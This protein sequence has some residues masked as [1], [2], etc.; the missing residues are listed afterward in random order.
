[1]VSPCPLGKASLARAQIRTQICSYA[2]PVMPPPQPLW[3]TCEDL[4]IVVPTY[5]EELRVARACGE[6]RILHG[7]RSTIRLILVM[8]KGEGTAM[9]GSAKGSP[10]N[11]GSRQVVMIVGPDGVGRL[12]SA[13]L[14]PSESRSMSPS[15]CWPSGPAPRDQGSCRTVSRAGPVPSPTATLPILRRYRWARRSTIRSTSHSGG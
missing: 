12:H 9:P 7:A 14:S 1:M 5:D 10:S 6:S 13:R 15:G 2:S 4:S 8:T 3:L 11:L